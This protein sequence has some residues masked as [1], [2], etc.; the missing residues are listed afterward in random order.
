MG[1][2]F[3]LLYAREMVGHEPVL[4]YC[5]AQEVS[6]TLS[7]APLAATTDIH[8]ATITATMRRS[9]VPDK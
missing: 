2:P 6:C 7:G 1:Q 8:F 9:E 4:R 3:M 5:P